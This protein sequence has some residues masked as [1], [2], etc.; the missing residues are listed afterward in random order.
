MGRRIYIIPNDKEIDE[1]VISAAKLASC[2]EIVKGIPS[3][4]AGVVTQDQLPLTYEE[5]EVPV[6]EPVNLLAM[7]NENT[8]LIVENTRQIE[9][10]GEELA[11]V[12]AALADLKA[13]VERM[14]ISGGA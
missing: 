1:K 3:A 12:Q 5:T 6:V 2:P 11:Q 14:E 9:L 13:R 10:F 8:A 4:L 7:I